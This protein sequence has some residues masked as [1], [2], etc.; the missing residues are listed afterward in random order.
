ME[1]PGRLGTF[2]LLALAAALPTLLLTDSVGARAQRTI[3]ATSARIDV[4]ASAVVGIPGSPLSLSGRAASKGRPC[5]TGRRV[6]LH[7]VS[8]SGDVLAGTARTSSK[9]RWT[10]E[11]ATPAGNF[12]SYVRITKKKAKRAICKRATS[13]PVRFTARTSPPPGVFLNATAPPAIYT[14]TA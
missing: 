1:T 12:S 8:A 7:V 10:I 5:M 14:P 13:P 2:A 4:P 3:F 11:T 9:G 6:W